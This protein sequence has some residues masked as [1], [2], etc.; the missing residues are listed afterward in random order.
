MASDD[1]YECPLW[2][3]NGHPVRLPPIYF[4]KQA[5]ARTQKAFRFTL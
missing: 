1:T 3:K 2:V 4:I 5:A